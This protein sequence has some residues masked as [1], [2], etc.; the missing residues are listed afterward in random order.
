MKKELENNNFSVFREILHR[1]EIEDSPSFSFTFN[2][3]RKIENVNVKLGWT[4]WLT[5]GISL[6]MIML[7]LAIIV[8]SKYYG[9]SYQLLDFSKFIPTSI[10]LSTIQLIIKTISIAG[11]LFMGTILVDKIKNNKIK[12]ENII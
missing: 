8:V 6:A 2:V 7:I 12:N 5:R 4:G 10:N 3:M 11:T 1:T 9:I